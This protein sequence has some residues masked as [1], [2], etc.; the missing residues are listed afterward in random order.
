[1]AAFSHSARA[2]GLLKSMWVGTLHAPSQPQNARSG[3]GGGGSSSRRAGSPLP[4]VEEEDEEEEAVEWQLQ[5]E[6]PPPT[7]VLTVGV[8]GAGKSTWAKAWGAEVVV[9]R[10]RRVVSADAVRWELTGS[11]APSP[12]EA[13][14]WKIVRERTAAALVQGCDV[15]LDATNTIARH[16]VRLLRTL[17]PC[18]PAA[19]VFAVACDEAR[20]RIRCDVDAGEERA[21]VPLPAIVRMH[22]QLTR[23]LGS[24]RDEGFSIL[25][26]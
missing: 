3:G 9:A 24:L 25:A 5:Y 18:V 2:T 10:P 21:D 11:V 19:R 16:R 4:E 15:V 13:E 1:M 7:L 26:P 17:P 6:G 14:V 12:I 23:D 20:R 8:P 22:A